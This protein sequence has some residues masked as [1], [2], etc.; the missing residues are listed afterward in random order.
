MVPVGCFQS[1]NEHIACAFMNINIWTGRFEISSLELI[2][3]TL[4]FCNTESYGILHVHILHCNSLLKDIALY[5][6]FTN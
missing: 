4:D 3:T 2:K 5:T 6:A 1:F